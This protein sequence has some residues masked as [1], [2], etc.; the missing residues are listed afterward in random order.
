MK[1][2]E[3]ISKLTDRQK[4]YDWSLLRQNHKKAH[5]FSGGSMSTLL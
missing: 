1:K 4:E 2:E 3:L 5:Y